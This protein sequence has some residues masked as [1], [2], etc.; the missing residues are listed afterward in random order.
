MHLLFQCPT[1][2]PH[3]SVTLHCPPCIYILDNICDK[4]VTQV[5]HLTEMSHF[6][7]WFPGG[8][9]HTRAMDTNTLVASPF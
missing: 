3:G 9:V 2:Y 6:L 5:S 8:L 1:R 4:L 7:S